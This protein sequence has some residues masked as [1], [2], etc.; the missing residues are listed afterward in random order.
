M[1]KVKGAVKRGKGQKARKFTLEAKIENDEKW[2]EFL[3]KLKELLERYN[4][5]KQVRV[6]RR[7]PK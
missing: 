5:D 7:S 2:A 4:V 6:L 1:S 3:E